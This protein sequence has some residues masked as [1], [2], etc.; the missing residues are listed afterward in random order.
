MVRLVSEGIDNFF[1]EGLLARPDKTLR[2][3][4]L[5]PSEPRSIVLYA[6]NQLHNPFVSTMDKITSTHSMRLSLRAS[7]L[8]RPS[9]CLEEVSVR[10]L[11]NGL[12]R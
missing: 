1:S 11:T 8:S 7:A 6:V 12:V 5:G 9:A 3:I 2:A 10:V 4:I